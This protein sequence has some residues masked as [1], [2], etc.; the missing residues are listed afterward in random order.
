MDR[1]ERD[2]GRGR[3]GSPGVPPR[4]R[5]F[6]T[7]WASLVETNKTNFYV[8]FYYYNHAFCGGLRAEFRVWHSGTETNYVMFNKVWPLSPFIH[9]LISPALSTCA[10]HPQP[11]Q[12]MLDVLSGCVPLKGKGCLQGVQGNSLAN[13]RVLFSKGVPKGTLMNLPQS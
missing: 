3:G 12:T 7:K 13:K 5:T 11:G 2:S 10:E 8:Y 6:S 9:V 1:G 4:C